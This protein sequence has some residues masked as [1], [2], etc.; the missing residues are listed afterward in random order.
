MKFKIGD[1]VKF[2]LSYGPGLVIG[3][4]TLQDSNK[5]FYFIP[6]VCYMV[7]FEHTEDSRYD[8]FI[9]EHRLR[10]FNED[11]ELYFKKYIE[12]KNN[13]NKFKIGDCVMNGSGFVGRIV[14]IKDRHVNEYYLE[15]AEEFGD[16][17]IFYKSEIIDS[18]RIVRVVK[19]MKV[20]K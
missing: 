19:K 3:I 2:N 15:P 5:D 17:S 10:V 9:E 13:S 20:K 14:D 11:H 8:G 7:Y 12:E 4:Y 6:S 16:K 18:G 1:R